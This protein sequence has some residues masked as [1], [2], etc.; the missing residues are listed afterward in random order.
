MV[1]GIE[2]AVLTG[3]ENAVH[4]ANFSPDGNQV[5]TASKDN[6]ARIWSK[7]SSV[8]LAVLPGHENTVTSA[9]FSPVGKQ[10]VTAS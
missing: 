3:H 4:S 8:E 7:P 2:L 1:S 10:I 9:N 6:T 5:V